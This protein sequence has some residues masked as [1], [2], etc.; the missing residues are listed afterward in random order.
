MSD[1]VTLKQTFSDDPA[2]TRRSRRAMRTRARA[3][4]VP[5]LLL[6]ILM[7]PVVA[8]GLTV[9]IFIRTSDY[10]PPDALRHLLALGG[11][12]I[13]ARVLLAPAREG[14]LGYHRRNDPDGDGVACADRMPRDV[15]PH[16]DT[17]VSK[18]IPSRAPPENA[19]RIVGGAK[20]LRP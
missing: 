1:L 15:Y 8:A 19:P 12:D 14:E 20:F 7:I 18:P 5:R 9:S 6:G 16:S 13:A 17:I 10:D 2:M 3:L 11:C 4:S